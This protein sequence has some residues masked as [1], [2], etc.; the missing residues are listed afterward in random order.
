MSEIEMEEYT[1]QNAAG[2][3]VLKHGKS[4]GT[5]LG[6]LNGLPTLTRKKSNDTESIAIETTFVG[7]GGEVF[8]DS[9]DSGAVVVDVEGRAMAMITGGSGPT[10][11]MGSDLTYATPLHHILNRVEEVLPGYTLYPNV[12]L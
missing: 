12:N 11:A 4:T 9:G 7:Y 8:S 2:T 6:R 3:I 10:D 5:T 1:K